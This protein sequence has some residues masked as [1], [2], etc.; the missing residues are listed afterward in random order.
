M[1]GDP[2]M[3][4]LRHRLHDDGGNALPFEL[5]PNHGGALEP[6]YLV[7]HYTAGRDAES[8]ICWFKNKDANSFRPPG[9]RKGRQCHS[10]GTV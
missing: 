9:D 8:S 10:D 5:T 4:F 6:E 1:K 2:I 3:K 7:L